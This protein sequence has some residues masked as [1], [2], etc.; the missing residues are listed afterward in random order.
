MFG[1]D[2]SALLWLMK[3]SGNAA[4]ATRGGKFAGPLIIPDLI[5]DSRMA[6]KYMDRIGRNKT[7]ALLWVCCIVCCIVPFSSLYG[8]VHVCFMYSYSCVL[9]S[10]WAVL[11]VTLIL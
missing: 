9:Y 4:D 5:P 8:S 6:E 11:L 10:H 3:Q 7:V 1:L 2:A